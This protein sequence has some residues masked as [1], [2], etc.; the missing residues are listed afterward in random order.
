MTE[1]TIGLI[2]GGFLCFISGFGVGGIIWMHFLKS[3]DELPRKVVPLLKKSKERRKPMVNDDAK[4]WK[5]EQ[6]EKNR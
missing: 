6:E 1:H 5:V 3:G 4:L 2:L